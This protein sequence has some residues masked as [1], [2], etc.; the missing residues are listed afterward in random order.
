MER[1]TL[2]NHNSH[3]LNLLYHSINQCRYDT[4]LSFLYRYFVPHNI[5]H[6]LT[7]CII[8][9]W[10]FWNNLHK[11]ESPCFRIFAFIKILSRACYCAAHI[12]YSISNCKCDECNHLCTPSISTDAS[13]VCYLKS[14]PCIFM[15]YNTL[16][17]YLLISLV[18][19][20]LLNTWDHDI[21]TCN[22]CLLD[23]F[24]IWTSGSSDPSTYC[25]SFMHSCWWV[26]TT[27]TIPRPPYCLYN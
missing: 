6:P 13:L 9:S 10:W 20:P 27:I 24:T 1:G 2:C 22:C 7:M 4:I 8:V 19:S 5:S 23:I 16:M 3:T 12:R 11:L 14:C 15:L 18:V 26:S 17:C 25:A 21:S